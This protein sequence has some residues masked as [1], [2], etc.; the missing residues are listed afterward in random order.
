MVICDQAIRE[1]GTGKISLIGIFENIHA[2][3][4]PIRHPSMA[5]YVQISDAQGEYDLRLELV[6]LDD[7]MTIGRGQGRASIGNRLQP[8]DILFNLLLLEFQRPGVYEFRLFAN[9]RHLASKSFRVIKFEQAAGE[10]AGGPH[11]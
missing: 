7:M 9:S 6:R 10:A 5:V 8:S 2:G 1:E 11:E 4:F 3:F